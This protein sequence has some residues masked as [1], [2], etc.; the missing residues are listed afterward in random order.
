MPELQLLQLSENANLGTMGTSLTPLQ[1]M[2]GLRTLELNNAGISTVADMGNLTQLNKL[3]LDRN[4]ALGEANEDFA[5]IGALANLSILSINESALTTIS[6]LSGLAN[7]AH[8]YLDNNRLTDESLSA[9][10]DMSTLSTLS[11]NNNELTVVN[12]SI[13]DISS[14]NNVSLRDNSIADFSPL[15]DNPSFAPA[16]LVIYGNLDN[17]FGGSATAEEKLTWCAAQQPVFE[18]LELRGTLVVDD[19]D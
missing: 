17:A 19:C 10:A 11:L 3:E 8:L 14:L 5:E 16:Q 1:A 7:I 2:V 4:V 9:I 15:L 12:A 13:A 6:G 18:A